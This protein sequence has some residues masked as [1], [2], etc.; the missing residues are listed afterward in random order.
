M[1]SFIEETR[2]FK[3][4]PWYSSKQYADLL[5]ANYKNFFS[6]FTNKINLKLEDSDNWY[7]SHVAP[8]DN[9]FNFYYLLS[10][11]GS[12]KD[13][14]WVSVNSLEQKFNK[15]FATT[16]TQQRIIANW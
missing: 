2:G 13:N 16:S 14:R 15:M 9:F 5:S 6:K 3:P 1:T 10:N 8:V 7:S 11:N 12:L 4:S